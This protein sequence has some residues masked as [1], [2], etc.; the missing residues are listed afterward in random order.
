MADSVVVIGLGRFGEAV[1]LEL[2]SA[3][4]DVLGV[5][6]REAPV[7]R[8]NGKLTHVVQADAT[9]EDAL[10]QLGVHEAEHV[11]VGIGDSIESSVLVASILLSFDVAQVWAKAVS[12]AHGR[13]LAQ[14]GVHHVIHP[15]REMGK[16]VAHLLRARVLN[17]IELSGGYA[18]VRT[19]PPAK[20]VG[21]PLAEARVKQT[22][23]VTVVAVK[24]P[25]DQW[26]DANGDV[27]LPADDEILVTGPAHKTE[28]FHARD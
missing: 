9:S 26:Q 21:R 18:L 24:G 19:N 10:R 2:M 3:G 20:L 14:L 27:V 12:D 23:G 15:E 7:Q 8:L 28:R 5:D 11:V 1:A 17:Y 25:D 6:S 22:Y 4:S 16:S 13:V